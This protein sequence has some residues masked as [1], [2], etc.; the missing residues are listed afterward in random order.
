MQFVPETP[1]KWLM[2]QRK[3]FPLRSEKEREGEIGERDGMVP[4]SL[5]LSHSRP[6]CARFTSC[7]CAASLSV[8]KMDCLLTREV[9]DAVAAIVAPPPLS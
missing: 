8:L 6:T 3:V 7:V 4:F 2:A 1:I 5:S 9:V